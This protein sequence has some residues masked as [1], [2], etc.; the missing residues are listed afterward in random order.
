MASNPQPPTA[1]TTQV[2]FGAARPETREDASVLASYVDETEAYS[3]QVLFR[4][5]EA[6]DHLYFIKAGVVELQVRETTPTL[7]PSLI[8]PLS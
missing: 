7:T 5:G 2:H 4:G 6:S 8:S 3:G 1:L